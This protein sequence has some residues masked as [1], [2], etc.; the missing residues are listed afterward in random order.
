MEDG[1]LITFKGETDGASLTGTFP[2]DSEVLHATVDYV[3]PD[4]GVKAKIWARR[5]SG[6]ACMVHLEHT[7]DVTADPPMWKKVDTFHLASEGE[8]SE[9][10][11]RPIVIQSR[12]GKQAFR[13]SWEQTTAA[14][15]YLGVEV[16][17]A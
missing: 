17:F 6:K 1:S 3:R 10:K 16:E 11:R 4:K 5:I 2:L 13:F 9:E 8:K 15:S 14:K 7:E 12:D